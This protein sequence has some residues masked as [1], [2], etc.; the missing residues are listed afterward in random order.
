MAVALLAL[1]VAPRASAQAP[2]GILSLGVRHSTLKNTARPMGELKSL[3][4]SLDVQIA[5]AAKLGRTSEI[6]RLYAHAATVL[7]RRPW[8]P[9]AEFASSL[10]S[11]TDRQ[12]ADPARRWSMRVEQIYAPTIQLD[13]PLVARATLRQRAA[14]SPPSEPMAV[15]KQLGAFDGVPRDLRDTPFTLEADLHDVVDGSY[16][17][18]VELLDSARTL[19][20]TTLSIVVR[21]GLEASIARLEAAAAK[22]PEPVRSDLLFPVDRLRNVN[23]NRIALGTFNP[24]RDF[25]AA[26]SLLVAANARKDPWSGRTGDLKQH[27]LLEAAAEVMPYRVYVPKGYTPAKPLPLIIALHGLGATED[28]FFDQY[29][30][31][32]PALAE[33]R[34]YILAAPLGYR[35]DGG[36]GVALGG[37]SGDPAASR[38]RA[39]S[40]QDVMQVLQSVRSR[41]KVDDRRVY[42][43]GHSMGA[44]GTWAIAAKTPSQWT[45]L[46]VFSGFGLASTAKTIGGIPQFVVHGDADPTVPVGGSRVMVAALKSVGADVQYLEVPGGDHSNV[47]EP[48]FAAMFDFFDRHA[49]RPIVKP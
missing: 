14:G 33:E 20:T 44:I 45:A 13:R 7:A 23:L 17:V 49:T 12:V 8:T 2:I 25:A 32:L 41:Y 39:L 30:R 21:T 19:G 26:E 4:D 34:G 28:S 6:R 35:V 11:R 16:V 47:V 31:R 22:A 27:Y 15:V 36:Y 24:A 38:A 43:M 10:I 37:P 9:E 1:T 48:N 29:G 3:V 40:E 18:A 5:A 42:L 46:G